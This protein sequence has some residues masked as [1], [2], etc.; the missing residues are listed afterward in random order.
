MLRAPCVHRTS[1]HLAH[2]APS[3]EDQSHLPEFKDARRD[4][5]DRY[6][7][8]AGNFSVR[9]ITA[10]VPNEMR[11]DSLFDTPDPSTPAL[12]Q[13]FFSFRATST[14]TIRAGNLKPMSSAALG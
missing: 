14:C 3:V 13:R 12:C 5:V 9:M 8:R 6:G 7:E 1:R 10:C 11:H 2:P 4:G